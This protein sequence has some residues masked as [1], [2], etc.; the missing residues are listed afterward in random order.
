MKTIII[1]YIDGKK[2]TIKDIKEWNFFGEVMVLDLKGDRKF[3]VR[4]LTEI[5]SYESKGQPTVNKK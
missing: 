4:K 5:D 3:L 1:T 2:E